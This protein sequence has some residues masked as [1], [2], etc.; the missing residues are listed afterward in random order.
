[1]CVC[2]ATVFAVWIST[3]KAQ[4]FSGGPG[5]LSAAHQS[6]LGTVELARLGGR[7][8]ANGQAHRGEYLGKVL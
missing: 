5:G 8:H 6:A 7:V 2:V 1:M 4:L 3:H